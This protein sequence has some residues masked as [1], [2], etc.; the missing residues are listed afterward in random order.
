MC[1]WRTSRAGPCSR[2]WVRSREHD[3]LQDNVVL[4]A[5][6]LLRL[7]LRRTQ[8]DVRLD[9]VLDYTQRVRFIVG[10]CDT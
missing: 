2:R 6:V 4:G 3:A 7:L 9:R 1:I 5:G 10:R 8:F